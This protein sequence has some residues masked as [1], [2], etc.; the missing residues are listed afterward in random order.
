MASVDDKVFWPFRAQ[1]YETS[2]GPL[3][4]YYMDKQSRIAAVRRMT[5]AKQL[6]AALGVPELQKTVNT[7]I[8]RR[9]K[10]I[11]K[12]SGAQNSQTNS[13]MREPK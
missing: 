2:T 3:Q 4:T 6:E 9:L 11:A 7:A 1:S 8:I 10:Q 13:Q 5:D 12:N